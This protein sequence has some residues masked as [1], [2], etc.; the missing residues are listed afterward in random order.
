MPKNIQMLVKFKS[1]G[2]V[3]PSFLFIRTPC[4]MFL[5]WCMLSLRLLLE[6]IS[7]VIHMGKLSSILLIKMSPRMARNIYQ[8]RSCMSG[9]HFVHQYRNAILLALLILI[10]FGPLLR[11]VVSYYST[12]QTSAPWNTTAGCWAIVYRVIHAKRAAARTHDACVFT[13]RQ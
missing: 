9:T 6:L 2:H 8:K 10:N 3:C 5:E 13:T 12:K 7:L 4:T 11:N 1:N